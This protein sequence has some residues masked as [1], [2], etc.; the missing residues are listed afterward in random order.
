MHFSALTTRLLAG[1]ATVRIVIA[2]AEPS[3]Q[4]GSYTLVMTAGSK[5]TQESIKFTVLN[6]V[7]NVTILT[8]PA[9]SAFASLQSWVVV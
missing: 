2:R 9:G 5:T 1:L 7:A 8:Q 6:P 4:V 3:S